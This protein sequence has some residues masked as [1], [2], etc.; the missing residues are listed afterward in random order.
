MAFAEALFAPHGPPRN[1]R[2]ASLDAWRGLACLLVV[3]H[4]ST[5]LLVRSADA[6]W[7]VDLPDAVFLTLKWLWL[8]VPMFFV[9]SGYC[10]A[11]TADASR[12]SSRTVGNFFVRR[13]RR[14]F[15]PYWVLW[16]VT[17]A[18]VTG[19]KAFW[20]TPKPFLVAP[21]EL[22]F[23]QWLGNLSLTEM[24]RP[25]VWGG[26]GR[27]FLDHAWTLCYEEQFYAVCGLLLLAGR[28]WFFRGLAAVTLLVLLVTP[29]SFKNVGISIGGF[30]WDGSWLLFACGILVYLRRNYATPTVGRL[31]DLSFAVAALLAL[32]LRHWAIAHLIVGNWEKMLLAQFVCAPIFAL[33]LSLT[34]RWDTAFQTSPVLKPFFFCG[35][36]CYSLYLVHYPIEA[37][38]AAWLVAHGIS[39]LV[40]TLLVTIPAGLIASLVAGW[41]FHRLVERRFLNSPTALRTVGHPAGIGTQ[42]L[43]PGATA[44]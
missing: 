20:G 14:I 32:W 8:G 41:W 35:R 16:L 29:L 30:F 23:P 38:I 7:P 36:M 15:P 28:R 25:H 5:S 1:P 40:P 17:G 3:V 9:I 18:L 42:A 39:G 11:A 19:F 24:W 37:V 44:Q 12:D 2:Y 33:T 34:Q 6:P 10:I 43:S 13:F 22:R 21:T 27:F 4:H 31:I 26:P